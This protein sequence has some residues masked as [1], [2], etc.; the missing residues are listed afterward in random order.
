MTQHPP[1]LVGISHGTSSDAGRVG[2][3]AARRR[4]RGDGAAAS[5]C[6]AAACGSDTSTSS[7]PTCRPP[8]PRSTPASPPWS[9][10]CCS[11]PGTTCTSTS[12][13]PSRPR[14]SA[15]SCSP[16]RSAPTT[17]SATVLLRRLRE[18]GPAR[19]RPDRARRRRGRATGVPSTTA[20]TW[21]PGSP[22]HPV[23]TSRSASCRRPSRACPTRS[24]G[25]RMRRRRRPGRGRELPARPGLLRRPRRAAGADVTARAAARAPTSRRRATL[26]EIVLDRYDAAAA[27]PRLTAHRARRRRTAARGIRHL[28]STLS[29][30]RRHDRVRVPQPPFDM[31]PCDAMRHGV[32]GRD[33]PLSAGAGLA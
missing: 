29:N 6:H 14:R 15:P 8:S 24:R 31:T 3:R 10:R 4:G 9:C 25:P 19:R 1:A 5:G 12:P 32:T 33:T 18:A 16:A 17:G 13:R 30:E 20:A 22:R 26:V 21:P 27:A 2:A 7:S 28:A 23:A 11:R